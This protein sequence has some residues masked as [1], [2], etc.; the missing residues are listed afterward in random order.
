MA[1]AAEPMLRRFYL[2]ALR[3]AAHDLWGQPGVR[4]ILEAMPHAERVEA[5]DETVREWVPERVVVAWGM[6]TWEGPAARDRARLNA[7]LARHVDHG[8]GRVR[9]FLMRMASPAHFFDQA[10]AFWRRDH[11]HGALETHHE[12]GAGLVRLREHPYAETPHMRAAIAE[13]FRYTVQSMR[14]RE[15]VETHALEPGG[16]LVIRIRWR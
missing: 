15:V 10:P 5:A 6:A 2:V 13:I 11:T 12:P 3:Q 14:A 1:T 7:F 4:A 8:F 16:A 9:R